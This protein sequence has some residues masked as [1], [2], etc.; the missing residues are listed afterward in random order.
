[1]H[2]IQL[3]KIQITFC[4]YAILVSV[5]IFFSYVYKTKNKC[6]LSEHRCDLKSNIEDKIPCRYCVTIYINFPHYLALSQA[7]SV[8]MH[9][10]WHWR[11][12]VGA[13]S[14]PLKVAPILRSVSTDFHLQSRRDS[15]CQMSALSRHGDCSWSGARASAIISSK[16]LTVLLHELKKCPARN[17]VVA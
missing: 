6:L 13:R 3:F 8:P 12:S 1:M 9:T 16:C 5:V 17:F 14:L 11:Y 4:F 7:A 2:M 15:D 10:V